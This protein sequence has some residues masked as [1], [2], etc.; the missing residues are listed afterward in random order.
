MIGKA[1]S[2]LNPSYH[3]QNHTLLRPLSASQSRFLSSTS[4]LDSPSTSSASSM[5]PP[6]SLDTINPKVLFLP[7]LYNTSFA[8]F[9]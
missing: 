8:A 1:K 9:D 6:V 4:V 2:L 7:P 5:Y 3:S